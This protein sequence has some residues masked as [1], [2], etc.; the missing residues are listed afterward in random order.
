MTV[1]FLKA[2][3]I[4]FDFFKAQWIPLKQNPSLSTKPAHLIQK[5]EQHEFSERS[6]CAG[7]WAAVTKRT[8]PLACPCSV[9]GSPSGRAAGAPRAGLG[10]EGAVEVAEGMSCDVI[11]MCP[12]KSVLG[13]KSL[14]P[15]SSLCA[16]GL[17]RHC[18]GQ[19][20]LEGI[21]GLSPLFRVQ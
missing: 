11:T 10:S 9:S 5:Q 14:P 7:L 20:V 1:L 18:V 6:S 19:L 15:A 4:F 12:S 13:Q 2:I 8:G 17:S 16:C 21:R 3:S